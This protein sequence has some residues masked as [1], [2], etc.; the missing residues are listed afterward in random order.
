MHDVTARRTCPDSYEWL[1]SRLMAAGMQMFTS[2]EDICS[3]GFP[4]SVASAWN[5]YFS[6]TGFIVFCWC[7]PSCGFPGARKTVKLDIMLT[8]SCIQGIY[9]MKLQSKCLKLKM[10]FDLSV[11]SYCNCRLSLWR[12]IRFCCMLCTLQNAWG[13]NQM[14]C[15]F[16]INSFVWALP[17]LWCLLIDNDSQ[18]WSLINALNPGCPNFFLG[19]AGTER[20]EQK[21][22]QCN[23]KIEIQAWNW[24]TRCKT[25]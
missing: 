4:E 24:L 21:M 14:F 17:C 1:M 15:Q 10:I 9:S 20:T 23:L 6:W 12:E 8:R 22:S 16:Q 18:E 13:V 19:K 11:Q 3:L 5:G 7:C 25:G 2:W